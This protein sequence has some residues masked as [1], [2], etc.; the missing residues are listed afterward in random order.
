MKEIFVTCKDKDL[1]HL[2]N[3]G[4]V[5]EV[6]DIN[7]VFNNILIKLKTNKHWYNFNDFDI[8][9]NSKTN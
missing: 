4:I 8:W 6:E 5:Y 1:Y 9:N 3:K 7:K 2:F